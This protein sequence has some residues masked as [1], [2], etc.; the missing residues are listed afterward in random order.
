MK[1]QI[2]RRCRCP[3]NAVLPYRYKGREREYFDPIVC[4]DKFKLLSE[5]QKINRAKEI[6]RDVPL[7]KTRT[8]VVKEDKIFNTELKKYE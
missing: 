7:S 1:R 8:Y 2:E 5:E 4:S 3:C 6:G